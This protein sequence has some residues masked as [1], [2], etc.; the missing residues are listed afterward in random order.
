MN[1]K[2]YCFIGLPCSGKTHVATLIGA[3]AFDSCTVMSAGAIARSLTTTDE[4]NTQ[5]QELDLFPNEDLIRATILSSVQKARTEVVVLDGVPRFGD[6][7]EWFCSK[8]WEFTPTVFQVSVGDTSILGD[9]AKL[10]H[11]DVRDTDPKLFTKRL[12]TASKNMT[13]VHTVLNKKLVPYY[14]ILNGSDDSI[15]LQFKRLIKK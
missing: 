13:D 9:R 3:R 6:Q 14:T 11:R 5:M 7:A 12:M 15:M 4:L 1:K 2:L 10:R 8:F